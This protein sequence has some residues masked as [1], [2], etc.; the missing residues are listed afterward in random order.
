M[1]FYKVPMRL[2]D[3]EPLWRYSER[4]NLC[5][6][7]P[8]GT[9]FVLYENKRWSG[10]RLVM[11]AGQLKKVVPQFDF[12]SVRHFDSFEDDDD[13]CDYAEC[14]AEAIRTAPSTIIDFCPS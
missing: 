4:G 12:R 13:A 1:P 2:G 9:M 8:H 5:L 6:R 14:I 10:P 11:Y 3:E 7:G